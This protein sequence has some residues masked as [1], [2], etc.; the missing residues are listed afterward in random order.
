VTDIVFVVRDL[1]RAKLEP[2]GEIGFAPF[3]G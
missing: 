3:D 1:V 2:V